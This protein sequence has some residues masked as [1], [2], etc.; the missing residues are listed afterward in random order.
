VKLRECGKLQFSPHSKRAI[1]LVEAD[2]DES[3]PLPLLG[4]VA[5]G[6]PIE[7]IEYF[8]KIQVPRSMI[9][10]PGS[11]FVLK[12]KGNSMIEDQICDGDYVVIKQQDTAQQGERVVALLDNDATLKRFYRKKD[13]VEL[14]PANSTMKPIIIEP[15]QHLRILGVYVGLIRIEK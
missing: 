13:R 9:K 6:L 14:H 1:E 8:D 10:G 5:A 2:E 15:H 7:A 11:Y 4:N 3:I 12:V